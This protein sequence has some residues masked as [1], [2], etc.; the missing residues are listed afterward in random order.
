MLISSSA[1]SQVVLALRSTAPYHRRGRAAVASRI[2]G[3]Y[4][5][6][7]P[8]VCFWASCSARCLIVSSIFGS[9]THEPGSMIG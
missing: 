1:R 6:T 8:A 4:S 9:I 7:Y 5:H 3:P 2:E